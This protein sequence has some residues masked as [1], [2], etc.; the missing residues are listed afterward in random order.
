MINSSIVL[1]PGDI[2]N[3][4]CGCELGNAALVVNGYIVPGANQLGDEIL[5]NLNISF[6]NILFGNNYSGY[7]VTIVASSETSGTYF[8]CISSDTGCSM[9]EKHIFTAKGD[10][11]DYFNA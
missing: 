6:E 4:T 8:T 10:H 5:A 9:T 3:Y 11:G 1:L 7:Y 2:F